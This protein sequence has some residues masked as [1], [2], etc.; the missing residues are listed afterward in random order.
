VGASVNV[1]E[2]V[3]LLREAAD[4]GIVEAALELGVL[5]QEGIGVSKSTLEACKFFQQAVEMGCS[6]SKERLA[7][8]FPSLSSEE[9]AA[10]AATG[11]TPSGAKGP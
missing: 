5:H 9:Q 3:R 2:G 8:L 7:N 1:E 4:G 11:A 10:A 6:K